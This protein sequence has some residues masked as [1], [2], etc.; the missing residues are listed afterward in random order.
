MPFLAA[1][2]NITAIQKSIDIF[3]SCLQLFRSSVR[4]ILQSGLDRLYAIIHRTKFRRR[5]VNLLLQI[6]IF[7]RIGFV[8]GL[9]FSQVGNF[10]LQFINLFLRLIRIEFDDGL[11]FLCM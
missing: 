3:D 8:V 6:L 9:F 10:F 2:L 4:H 1:T 5:F 11:I 7:D